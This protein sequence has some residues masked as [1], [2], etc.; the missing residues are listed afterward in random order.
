MKVTDF[1]K[2]IIED[3][4]DYQGAYPNIANISKDEWAF[5]FWVLDKLFSVDENLIEERIVDYDD[6]GIDCF[7][8]H[9]DLKDLYLIQNKFY[10]EG[11]M[12]TN[13]YVQNDFLTRAIGAL[14]KGTYTRSAELQD[15]YNKYHEDEDFCIHFYL[16]VTNNTAKSNGIVDGLAK[17]NE[18]YAKKRY[19]ARIFSLDDIQELYYKEPITDRKSF[20]YEITTINKGTILNV[21]N[22]AYKMTLAL[23]AKYVLTPV[24]VMYRMVRDAEKE[25][26]P[27]FDENIREYLGSTGAVNKRIVNTL[28]DPNDRKNFFFYNNGITMIVSDISKETT[29]GT[30]RVFEVSDPQ[31]V[32]GC[33][34]VSTI[35]E[36]LDKL[37]VSTLEEEFANTF[38]MVKILKIPSSDD[39]LKDLYK[40][41][42]TYN[43][44]QNSINEKAFT[45]AKDV[46]KHVQSEFEWRGYLVCVKQSDKNTFVKKYKTATQLINENKKWTN[47]FGIEGVTKTKDFIIDLEKVLQVILA[48]TSNPQDAIQ[49]K[50]KLLKDQ[51]S[52]NQQVVNFI[53]SAVAT[54]N[55]IFSLVMLYLRAEQE[56]KKSDDGKTPNPFYLI[57]CFA[58]YECRG[59]SSKI[60]S[61]LSN[62]DDINALIKKYIFVQKVYYQKWVKKNAGKEYNDMIKAA[63][64][65]DLLDE[66]KSEAEVF[67]AL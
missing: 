13:S 45:A 50:S 65:M 64:D 12:L 28:T 6:K 54:S 63:I 15:I 19:D 62:K 2:Q 33:Q 40:N 34:T 46:F 53:T 59:D 31:I 7:V 27:L 38:V 25:K 1:K 17:F 23:D 3:I 35:Y 22:A 51:S 49:N 29:K 8:W 9:E 37:T 55:D 58:H 52:Q 18:Q 21:D 14:E 61:L 42:V 48:F 56:K 24:T 57:F 30:S 47:Q 41:I 26:Y 44:S 10:S 66:C 5:N 67:L 11:T 43:N 36:T 32:N 60:S 39:R 4:R 16:Y 20:K